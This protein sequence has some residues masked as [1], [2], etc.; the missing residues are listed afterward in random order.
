MSAAIPGSAIMRLSFHF[1]AREQTAQF[2]RNFSAFNTGFDSSF[3]TDDFF[4]AAL[5]AGFH[6]YA[7]AAVSSYAE[8]LGMK[9]YLKPLGS[10]PII[11]RNATGAGACSGPAELLPTQCCGLIS[12]KSNVGGS[13]GRGRDYIPFPAATDANVYGEVG[14]A[15]T[16]AMTA[17]AGSLI[18]G[19]VVPNTGAGFGT[20][21]VRPCT[22]YTVGS[23]TPL[24]LPMTDYIIGTGFATQRKRGYYGRVN[25]SEF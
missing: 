6:T 21:V 11:A 22:L 18:T 20:L 3:D 9:I 16:S 1:H 10:P 15:Y 23:S 12:W 4:A 25:R 2:D 19:V 13:Q 14:T 8:Y 17:L 5:T 24:P 7:K